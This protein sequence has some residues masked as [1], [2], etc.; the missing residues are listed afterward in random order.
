MIRVRLFLV[1]TLV[2]IILLTGCIQIQA[3][4]TPEPAAQASNRMF[5]QASQL[6]QILSS[7]T[8]IQM[9]V[10][11]YYQYEGRYPSSLDEIGLN[12]ADMAT[13]QYIDDLELDQDGNILIAASAELGEDIFVNLEH[14]ET[15]G[16]LQ[17]V[18]K[19]K[20]N[21]NKSALVSLPACTYLEDIRT[22]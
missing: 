11:Q 2:L 6:A 8:P 5:V 18:W 19:C 16:G 4:D 22:L 21:L 17:T 7:V 10:L 14:E 1:K 15:M 13:G 3:V 20:T 9:M 12:R